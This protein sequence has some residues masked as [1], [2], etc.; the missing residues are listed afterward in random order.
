MQNVQQTKEMLAFLFSL[1]MAYDKSTDDGKID[2]T[3]ISN[4]IEPAKLALPA[5][6]SV[7]SIKDELLTLSA[8]DK[9]ELVKWA[10]ETYNIKNDKLEEIVE[11]GLS[12]FLSLGRFILKLTKK[13]P[14][15]EVGA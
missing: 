3:D 15:A 4:L 1:H 12:L 11:E 6:D 2:W 13:A 8:E 5:I 9:A 10:E 14:A 7:A